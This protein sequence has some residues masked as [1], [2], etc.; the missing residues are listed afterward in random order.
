MT[1]L[2]YDFD[3]TLD[4]TIKIY[5]PAFK[6]AYQYLMDKGLAENRG[7]TNE[8]ERC[9]CMKAARKHRKH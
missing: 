8:E 6:K 2:V 9:G 3:G 4:D 1:N 7:W 5:G